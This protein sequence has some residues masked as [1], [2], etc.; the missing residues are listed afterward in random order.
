MSDT[1]LEQM[2]KNFEYDHWANTHYLQA[3]LDMSAP[4]EKAIKLLAHMVFAKDVWLARLLKE[5]LSR[6]KD[7]NPN[8]TLVECREKL[9]ALHQKWNGYLTS[10]SP[11]GLIGVFTAPNTQGKVSEHRV[12]NVLIHVV[13]HATH[14]RGQLATLVH[15]AGGKRP[16]T[17]YISYAYEIGESK[18]V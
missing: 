8:Y 16:G 18:L 10:L 6:F 3:L 5:D 14:H 1:L 4:P 9:E 11:E 17:D 15:Q 13:N 12:Q 7:P 2:R